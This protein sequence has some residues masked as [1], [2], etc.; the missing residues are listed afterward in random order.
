M[1]SNEWLAQTKAG[2]GIVP[3]SHFVQI[4]VAYGAAVL[5]P[6]SGIIVRP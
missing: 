5:L 6:D 1:L 4:F 2:I 3:T